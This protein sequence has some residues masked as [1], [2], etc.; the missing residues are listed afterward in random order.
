[1]AR[2]T[3]LGYIRCTAVE[4]DDTF[5]GTHAQRR[6]IQAYARFKG[7][8]LEDVL[9]DEGVDAGVPLEA[10][11][12]GRQ[13]VERLRQ[14]EARGLHVLVYQLER[15]FSTPAE[16]VALEEEWQAHEIV[17]HVLDLDGTVVH[18]AEPLGKFM[19]SVL[20]SAQ[21]MEVA[22]ARE[23]TTGAQAKRPRK[24]G[25]KP[26]LGERVIRGYIVPDHD[27][28]RAVA[29]IQ[30]LKEKGKSLRVIAETLDE[31]GVPTKRRAKAW[32]KEAIR[33][34]LQRIEKGEVRSLRREI[35]V[36]DLR[37]GAKE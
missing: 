36:V 11:P 16:C 2:P 21:T 7:L 20:E 4:A 30:E 8:T 12:A 13:L 1:M 29:R 22:A 3:A 9:V 35:E 15:C 28:M 26:L 23:R 14:S 34:I 31:E 32:S 25:G 37:K 24:G 6:S 17:L 19:L 27:E 33:L 10:R 18:T 5:L